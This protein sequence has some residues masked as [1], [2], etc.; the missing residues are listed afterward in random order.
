GIT[1][2]ECLMSGLAIFGLKYPSLLQFDQSMDDDIIKQNLNNLYGIKHAPSDTWFRE[3]LD[4]LKP[5]EIRK[6]FK[7]ILSTVQR[8]KGLESF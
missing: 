5:E 4:E 3:R 2:S 7:A 8:G 1:L 6:V